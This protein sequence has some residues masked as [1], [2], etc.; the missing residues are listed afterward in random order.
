MSGGVCRDAGKR[1]LRRADAV[2]RRFRWETEHLTE[3]NTV[4]TDNPYNLDMESTEPQAMC[5]GRAGEEVLKETFR[6][7]FGGLNYFF[8]AEQAELTYAMLLRISVLTRRNTATTPTAM[9]RSIRGI[10]PKAKQESCT[11]GSGTESS[12]PAVSI[13]SG[14]R[15]CNCCS[16]EA[17]VCRPLSERHRAMSGAFRKENDEGHSGLC[18]RCR[19]A[20]HRLTQGR[21]F[22]GFQQL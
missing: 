6:D 15:K 12:M 4:N 7:Y 19:G 9:L 22:Y 20:S 3:G 14:F 1:V 18:R 2:S 13:T 16:S 17:C 10:P 5:S 8:A 21:Y 11:S